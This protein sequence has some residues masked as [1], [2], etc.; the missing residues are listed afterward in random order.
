ML[1]YC[2]ICVNLVSF[3]QSL[4]R[5]LLILIR[6]PMAWAVTSE[7]YPSRYRSTYIA[8]CAASNWLFNFIIG[9]ATPFVTSDIG[10]SYGYL[11][12]VCNF[13][14]VLVIFFFLPETSGKSLEEIE[15]MFLQRVKPWKSSKWRILEGETLDST[16]R[17]ASEAYA[18]RRASRASRVSRSYGTRQNSVAH[19][20]QSRNPR[21][22][23]KESH[24]VQIS[25]LN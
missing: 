15:T 18:T 8:L 16:D 24:E 10:F 11:F 19:A 12:A 2:S 4:T 7:I 3:T 17:R 9:F 13:I 21:K 1:V 14:A 20:Q 22:Q 5:G 25:H 23:T 6:G